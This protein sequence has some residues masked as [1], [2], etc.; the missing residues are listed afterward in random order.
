LKLPKVINDL[1]G[2]NSPNLVTLYRTQDPTATNYNV[3]VEAVHS[4]MSSLVRFEN[5][6]NPTYFERGYVPIY[7][8]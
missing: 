5:K 2:E 3:S 8:V 4:D 7:V 1:I 6:K